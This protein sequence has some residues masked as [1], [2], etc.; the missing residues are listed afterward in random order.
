MG[1][2]TV[3]A[4]ALLGRA[5]YYLL[6]TTYYLLPTTYNDCYLQLLLLLH[7]L[8]LLLLLLLLPTYL[9]RTYN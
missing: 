4:P 3:R 9:P 6:P 5:V 7:L 1:R 2:M 8:L